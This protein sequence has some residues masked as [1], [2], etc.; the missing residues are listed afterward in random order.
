M[1]WQDRLTRARWRGQEFLTEAHGA[2]GGR[3]LAVHQY[4]GLDAPVVEDMG[5]SAPAWQLTAY[6]IGQ[7]YD[8]ERNAFLDA[9]SIPGPAW[10]THPWLGDVW[11]R[12][13]S[14][15][16]SES[17]AQGGLA[18]VTVEFVAGGGDWYDVARTGQ[19]RVFAERPEL[20]AAPDRTDV[21]VASVRRA[22]A[23]AEAA[24]R[25]ETMSANSLGKLIAKVSGKLERLRNLI[26]LAR[27]PLVWIGQVRAVIEGIKTDIAE[28]MAIPGQYA[29]ALRGLANLLGLDAA[30]ADLDD[31]ARVR[32]VT[33]LALEAV[34]RASTVLVGVEP[35]LARNTQREEALSGVLLA[36]A[37]AGLALTDYQAAADRDAAL[38]AVQGAVDAWLPQVEDAQFAA[39]V[40]MRAAVTAALLA[41]D[42]APA[43]SRAVV[44]ALPA[45]VLAHR[46]E[47][48]EAVLM[49]RNGVTHPL[50]VSG[51]VSS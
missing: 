12:V 8:L 29:A 11:A 5:G 1:S 16:L 26:S 22:A 50:F 48:D 38:A 24:Y 17:N 27:L 37:A 39:L 44:H 15:S 45:T 42:L 21:A 43:T 49:R 51:E 36:T 32:A 10:L 20:R 4:P 30:D 18:T 41:Q 9:L 3:R 19:A 6:F 23:T 47:A 25:P 13:Q 40:D 34:T 28:L 2:R 46:M 7:S 33:S 31:A 14:W 35:A